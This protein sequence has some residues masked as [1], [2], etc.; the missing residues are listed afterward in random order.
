MRASRRHHAR[1][2]HRGR[3]SARR[4]AAAVAAVGAVVA[5][6]TLSLTAGALP[7]SAAG[8]YTVTATIPVGADP[9]GVAVDPAAGTVYVAN[10]GAGT[11]SVSGP[12]RPAATARAGLRALSGPAAAGG[13]ASHHLDLQRADGLADRS[14]QR[15]GEPLLGVQGHPRT[16][17]LAAAVT[18]TDSRGTSQGLPGERGPGVYRKPVRIGPF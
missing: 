14:L 2:G 7:A 16:M 18:V 9:E 5:A 13:S 3:T 4:R 6:A 17:G 15:R 10:S 12:G 1:V 11:V 8:G